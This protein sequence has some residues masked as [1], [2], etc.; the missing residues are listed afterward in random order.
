MEGLA[1]K[2]AQ[3]VVPAVARLGVLKRLH[4]SHQGIERTKQRARQTVW[5]SSIN[6][7]ITT[8][9]KTC[10]S[11]Q[12]YQCSQLKEPLL[13]QPIALRAFEAASV[14]FCHHAG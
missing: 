2:G 10:D 3:I 13:N 9:V 8:T 7:D 6:N 4:I 12:Q 1:L 5:W 14:D 11:C